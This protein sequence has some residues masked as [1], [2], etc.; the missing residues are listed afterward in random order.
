VDNIRD[1]SVVEAANSP[2]FNAIRQEFPYNENA[3]L[4]RPCMIID[5]P[6][7]LRKLVDQYLVPQ[8]HEHSEDIIHE[9]SVVAWID[10]YAESLKKLTDPV[11][12]RQ[13]QD[14]SNRWYREGEEYKS[15]FRFRKRV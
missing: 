9:P 14:P 13:I 4:K 1:K 3:N 2:F 15:L 5:T 6:D 11:W 8:G 7:G 10:S 12:E